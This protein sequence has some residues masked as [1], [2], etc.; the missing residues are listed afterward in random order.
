MENQTTTNL[1]ETP[2]TDANII[3]NQKWHGE[4]VP[5]S[6]SKELE[7]ENQKLKS[8][9]KEAITWDGFDEQGVP[10]VWLEAA[11]KLLQEE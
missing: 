8:V 3:P 7:I 10:A 9:L 2:R 11:E 6:L 1:P 4:L 5:A